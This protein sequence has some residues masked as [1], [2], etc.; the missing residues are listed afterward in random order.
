MK[1]ALR[2]GLNLVLAIA[3][4]AL[5]V[6]YIGVNSILMTAVINDLRL[7]TY[8]APDT[9]FG[10]VMLILLL[11]WGPLWLARSVSQHRR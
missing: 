6:I 8:V 11:G 3:L 9:G 4:C 10:I 7:D 5:C 2:H 1:E